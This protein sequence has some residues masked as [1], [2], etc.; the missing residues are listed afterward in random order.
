MKREREEIKNA[1]KLI[2]FNPKEGWGSTYYKRF[3][4]HDEYEIIITLDD[5]SL[6]KSKIDYGNKIE[7]VRGTITNF[8]RDENLVVLECVNRLLEKG[9]KP[10][11]LILEKKWG[12]GHKEKGFLDI[13]VL[14]ER[15]KK[16]FLMVECK[17][18]ESE[19]EKEKQK[20]VS[21][22]GQLFSYYIQEPETEYL[23]LYFSELCGNR[24]G[25]KNSIIKVKEDFKNKN[26]DEIHELW[27]K[28]FGEYGLFEEG[29]EPYILKFSCVKKCQLKE[30]QVNDGR[31]IFNRFAEILR[32][33]VVSDKTNAY[34]KIFNLFLC[35]IV[36]EDLKKDHEE[37]DFQWREDEDNKTV[38]LR[39]N[40]LYKKGMNEYLQI[41]IA[42]YT[43]KEI[44]G[45]LS[46]ISK[47]SVEKLRE[48]IIELRLYTNN[49]FAFKEVFDKKTFENNC[50]VVKEVV[51]LL[52]GYMLKYTTKHQFL[53]N[54]F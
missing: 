18:K 5:L 22:G 38:M 41:N 28:L 10:E 30:L 19:Y 25:Y 26:Q 8:S 39:L 29:I 49:E 15:T 2:G 23:C 52:Q 17:R 3:S 9:Y 36:D 24:I 37:M 11:N 7:V 12:L 44:D 47:D 54:F 42:D 51:Q 6:K 1:L 16:T 31:F 32:K 33:N 14:N 43:Q 53:G 35:K 4:N 48:I 27:D 34:N 21:K 46:S 50:V 13:L 20:M 45:I 40:D